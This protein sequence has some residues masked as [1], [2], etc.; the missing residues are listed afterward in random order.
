M[1]HFQGFRNQRSLLTIP[2]RSGAVAAKRVPAELDKCFASRFIY[3]P[4]PIS[5]IR[6]MMLHLPK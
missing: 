4:S 5:R 2:M 3:A 1:V 6:K